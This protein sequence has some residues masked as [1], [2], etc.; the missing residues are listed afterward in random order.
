MVPE[1][2]KRNT[3]RLLAIYTS[4]IFLL[5]STLIGGY[6]LGYLIDDSLGTAPWLAIVGLVL[7][8]IGGFLHLFRLLNRY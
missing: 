1:P 2:R 8:G 4:L 7:G 3:Y 6:Y 5:P